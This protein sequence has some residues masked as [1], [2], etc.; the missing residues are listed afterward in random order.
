M[1]LPRMI[2]IDEPKVVTEK[3]NIW[4]TVISNNFEESTHSYLIPQGI[5]KLLDYRY[6]FQSLGNSP[7]N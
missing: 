5:G 3:V 4:F 6:W 1:V 2:S 7:R